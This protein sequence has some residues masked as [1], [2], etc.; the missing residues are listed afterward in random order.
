MSDLDKANSLRGK[1]GRHTSLKAISPLI[2]TLILIAITIVG[3][4]VVYRL[5]FSAGGAIS[6]NV[7]AVISDA[8]V[9]S[10]AGLTITVKNDGSVGITVTAISISGAAATGVSPA[11]GGTIAPGGSLAYTATNAATAGTTYNIRVTV[12]GTGTTGTFTTSL[13]VVATT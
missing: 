11:L 9:S 4:V 13:N 12:S 1:R 6:S 2:A 10:A 7:H 5:F 8:S 3:G